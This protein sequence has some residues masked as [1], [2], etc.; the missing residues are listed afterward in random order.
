MKASTVYGALC[1]AVLILCTY[2]TASGACASPEASLAAWWPGEDDAYDLISGT[3]ARVFGAV[4]FPGGVVN[5]CFDFDGSGSHVRIADNPKL[6]F[7]SLTVEAW[8]YPRSHGKYHELI[9]KWNVAPVGGYSYDV[10][11]HPDGRAYMVLCSDGQSDFASVMSTNFLPL[12]QWTHVAATY[13]GAAIK[14]YVNGAYQNQTLF[15]RGIYAG[16]LDLG[17][18]GAVGGAAPGQA[19]YP[20]DGR[21]DEPSLYA[22]AL[23]EAQIKAIFDAG[24]A[25]KC[26]LGPSCTPPPSELVGWWRAEG[27]AK[28]AITGTEGRLLGGAAFQ[29]GRVGSAFDLGG[30]GAHVR[31]ADSPALHA[32]NAL[33]IEAWV[34]PTRQGVNQALVSKWCAAVG[35]PNFSYALALHSDGRCYLALSSDGQSAASGSVF[36][37]NALPLKEWTHLVGT[38][39]G[40]RD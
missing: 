4:S 14:I 19:A 21:I 27:D 28:D 7:S 5:Q 1:S 38:H 29:V 30:A 25:G 11:L 35:N 18:G 2:E 40:I 37:T 22:Q 16:T 24:S 9:S 33:S 17:I 39:D 32:T 10:A 23:T 34:F 3:P 20:F 6:R 15:N 26:H 12:N 13:D 8:V 36:S 31:V